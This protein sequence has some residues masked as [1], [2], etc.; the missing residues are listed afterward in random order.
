VTVF[1]WRVR[2]YYEDT[3]SGGVVY[4]ANYLRFMERA[5]TEWMRARDFEQDRLRA[6]HGVLFAVRSAHVEFLLPAR[7]N[8]QLDVSVELQDVGRASLT[9]RQNVS[10][11]V[12]VQLLCSGTMRI[13]CVDADTFRPK[14]I[15]D[16][17]LKEL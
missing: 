13:A 4:Y 6:E 16:F 12:D 17:I 2:V 3:D 9:F 8:E 10:R 1:Q 14:P 7:F 11:A 5:R 15:P